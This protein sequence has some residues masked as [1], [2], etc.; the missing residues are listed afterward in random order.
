MEA[1]ARQRTFYDSK[2]NTTIHG[3]TKSYT[4]RVL[5]SAEVD[6]DARSF[7]RTPQRPKEAM[8]AIDEALEQTESATGS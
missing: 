3:D 4:S 7:T 5:P 2:V 1:Y 6:A 8:T